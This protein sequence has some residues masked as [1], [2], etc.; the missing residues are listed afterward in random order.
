V[1]KTG[2]QSGG[3]LQLVLLGAFLLIAILFLLTQQNTLRT[4]RT[5]NRLMPPG[6]VW[7][8]LVPLFG[9]IWQF[10]AVTRISESIRNEIASW[11]NDSILGTEAVAV[12]Q[13]NN[14]PT[15]GI[16]ITYCVLTI[17]WIITNAT[18]RTT[19]PVFVTLLALGM[20]ICWITYWVNLAGYK[21]KLRAKNLATI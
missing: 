1:E 12:A 8:Q 16:G 4:I 17:I 13:G 10:F 3:L 15:L 2:Y 5:E 20:M 14:R 19:L 7:L 11:D 21:R 6:Q 9:L 18:V